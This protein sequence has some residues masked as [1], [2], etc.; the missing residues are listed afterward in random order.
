MSKYLFILLLAVF[1]AGCN[2]DLSDG[3]SSSNQSGSAMYASSG[4]SGD[5]LGGSSDG[6]SGGSSGDSVH[7]VH[8]PEPASLALLGMGLA[9]LALRGRKKA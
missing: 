3:G 1:L 4:S 2:E 9:G 5:L 6:S 7:K 8:N